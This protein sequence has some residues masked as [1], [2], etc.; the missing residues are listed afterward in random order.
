MALDDEGFWRA[1]ID[2][3][4]CISCGKCRDVCPFVERA[5]SLPLKKGRLFSYKDRSPDVLIASSSGGAAAEIAL[6]SARGGSAVLG[7]VFDRE[8]RGAAHLLVEPDDA[9]GLTRLA[10]SKYMQSRMHPALAAAASYD[11]PLTVFGTPC[12]VAAARN[13]MSHRDD[14]LYVDLICHGV[15]SRYL[16]DRYLDWLHRNHGLDSLRTR[17][18]FRYKPRGWRERYLFSTD[19][20]CSVCLFQRDDPYFQ[21]FDIGQCYAECC[22]ECPWR[23][24]SAADLRLGDYWGPRFRKDRTGVSMVLAMTGRGASALED[25]ALSGELLPWPL[26]DYM[27]YQQVENVPAPVYRGRLISALS[28]PETRIDDVEREFA[29]PEASKR[30]FLGW[31]APMSRLAKRVLKGRS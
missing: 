10:G 4:L 11:G 25:L 18:E 6:T 23:S 16:Y 15:P 2:Q 9:D 29:A 8:S 24:T 27:S 20:S 19:G 5:T 22:Y 21:L 26:D 14:V 17:T 30:R 28:N 12:Q 13:L 7:C 1:R 31:L 3:D